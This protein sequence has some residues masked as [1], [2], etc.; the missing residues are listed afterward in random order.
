MSKL[1]VGLG[2]VVTVAAG[3]AIFIQQQSIAELRGELALDR[4]ERLQAAKQQARVASERRV[5]AD[6]AGPGGGEICE[7]A[8]GREIERRLR[9]GISGKS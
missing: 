7:A 2:I 8:R 5:A 3:A 4:A 9:D 6:V 1:T